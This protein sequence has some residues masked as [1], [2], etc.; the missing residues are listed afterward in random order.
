MAEHKYIIAVEKKLEISYWHNSCSI[1]SDAGFH[2][3]LV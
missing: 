3:V 1:C 2:Q